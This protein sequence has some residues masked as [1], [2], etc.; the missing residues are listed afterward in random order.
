MLQQRRGWSPKDYELEPL[1]DWDNARAFLVRAVPTHR[2]SFAPVFWVNGR[3][4]R[5]QWDSAVLDEVLRTGFP[6]PTPTD[7]RS[8]ARLAIIFGKWVHPVGILVEDALPATL[9]PPQ[10]LPRA[11]S[12]PTLTVEGHKFH[13]AFYT[14]EPELMDLFDAHLVLTSNSKAS[15]Q[16]TLLTPPRQQSPP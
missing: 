6:N 4:V 8:L 1:P 12:R 9:N 11:D 7:A 10:R 15:V 3:R 5:S 16:A 13:L 14:Y 2:G